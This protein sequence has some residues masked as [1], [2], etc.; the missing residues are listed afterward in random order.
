MNQQD[1]NNA[2]GW[3]EFDSS[4]KHPGGEEQKNQSENP[5]FG[6]TG[7]PSFKF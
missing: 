2:G 1:F 4:F 6:F 5:G 3:G 7:F